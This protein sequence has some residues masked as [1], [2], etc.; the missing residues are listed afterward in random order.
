MLR[1][2]PYTETMQAEWDA[3]ALRH[4]SVF[5]TTGFRRILLE[6]FPYTCAY[7]AV[8]DQ[9]DRICGLLPLVT[10][11]NLRLQRTGVALP[12][13]NHLNI[14][15]AA[16]EPVRFIMAELSALRTDL[17]LS[18]LE[19]RLKDQPAVQPKWHAN[20]DHHTFLLKLLSDE[21]GTLAQASA[22]C[23]NHVRKTYRNGWFESSFAPERLE[24]FYAVYVRRMRQLGSPAPAS[25]FFRRFFVHL[26]DHA[27]LLT[28]LDPATDKVVGGMLLLRSPGDATLYYPY[29]AGLIEYNHHYLNNFMYWEAVRFGLHGGFKQLDLGRSQMDSGTYRFKAQWGAQPVQ[30]KYFR[31]GDSG[32]AA[33]DNRASLKPL[34]E[35]W[36][37]LPRFLTDPVGRNLIGYLLP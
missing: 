37:H 12:F 26:P 5:H 23:R 31:S 6:S 34:S 35:L 2:V 30:L 29:G 21:A 19:I 17:G 25:D 8:L 16:E 9:Q 10:G 36:K 24:E 20:L 1:L 33:M 32:G 27:A 11:R 18:S 7:R 22:G 14:C 4:G 28:V 15:A 13:V 3:F